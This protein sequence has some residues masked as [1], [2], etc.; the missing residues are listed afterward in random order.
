MTVASPAQKS[1]DISTARAI[2]PAG[3]P[4]SGL[5]AGRHASSRRDGPGQGAIGGL[6]TGPLWAPMV[7]RYWGMAKLWHGLP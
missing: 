5:D 4:F 3:E 7:G 1:A 2:P 6:G